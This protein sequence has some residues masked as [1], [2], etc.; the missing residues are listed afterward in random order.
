MPETP[1]RR[2]LLQITATVGACA[3]AHPAMLRAQPLAAAAAPAPGSPII[4]AARA[5]LQRAGARITHLDVVGVADFTQPS[6]HPRF[7]LVDIVGGRVTSLLV[8]HGRGS[9]PAHTGW[10]GRFSNT[11]GSDCTS[12]GDFLTS[13]DY[14]GQHGRSM[15]LAGLDATNSN[16][17]ARGLVVHSAAYVSPEIVREHGV[18]GRSEGCFAL[19]AADLPQVL[20][21]L[22]PGRLLVSAKL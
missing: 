19:S 10:L 5:G 9:D 21:R 14:V 7:H 18:L 11:P 8:A 20:E 1:S 22:G 17:E 6:S 3:L 12:E 4:A 15:R 16:A 13:A 2:H